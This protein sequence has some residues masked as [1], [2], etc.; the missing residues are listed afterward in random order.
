MKFTIR[1]KT[2]TRTRTNAIV[3]NFDQKIL[4]LLF[5]ARHEI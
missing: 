2:K 5:S 1:H 3:L 4:G